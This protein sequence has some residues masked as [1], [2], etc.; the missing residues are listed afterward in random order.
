ML[1][2]LFKFLVV[3]Y[4]K[5]AAVRNLEVRTVVGCVIQG[6]EVCIRTVLIICRYLMVIR[7]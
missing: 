7:L 4:L 2:N 1:F 5:M 6:N 3:D